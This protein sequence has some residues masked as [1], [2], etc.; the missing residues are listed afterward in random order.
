MRIIA[1]GFRSLVRL[2]TY[3]V[4]PEFSRRVRGVVLSPLG[5]LL[6]AAAV[7]ILVGLVLHPRVFAL[8]GGLL[9]VALGGVCWP[10]VTVRACRAEIRFDRERC[11]AGE[12]VVVTITLQNPLLWGARGLTVVGDT[13]ESPPVRLPVVSG[14]TR[15]EARWEFVPP[16]RGVYPRTSWQIAT[17]FPFG[18][19]MVR[20]PVRVERPLVVWPQTL[21]VGPVP[22]AH[23]EDVAEG[24]VSRNRAGSSGDLFGVRPY[25][26]G[27]SPRW[28]H[29][30]QSA[31]HD[32]LVVCELQSNSRPVV[33]L[34]LDLDEANHTPGDNGTREWAI[35]VAA[36]LAAGWLETG[37]Q[38]GAAWGDVVCEPQSGNGQRDRILDGLARIDR[39]AI[40][41]ETL[42]QN[43]QLRAA[44]A[45]VV[46]RIGTTFPERFLEFGDV[47]TVRLLPGGFGGSDRPLTHCES[48]VNWLTLSSAA[49]IAHQL[50]HGTVE[51]AH[52]G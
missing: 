21:P 33:L 23:G 15:T 47:R 16:G 6:I 28:I 13:Q 27:D 43:P 5:V 17:G 30:A 37:A 9:L 12:P 7:A 32:R 11:S 46:V 26:R 31:R 45:G 2:A 14:R 1:P 39:S 4:S 25:R 19:W 29:W 24:T 38:V 51:A 8:A 22:V 42:L 44:R 49:G 40:P 10:W 36:S 20:K 35:R 3:D 48:G 34:I 41:L 52:G 18:L 50:K